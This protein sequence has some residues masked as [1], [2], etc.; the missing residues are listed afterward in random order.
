MVIGCDRLAKQSPFGVDFKKN[1]LHITEHG[2]TPMIFPTLS[3]QQ[4]VKE[5][6]SEEMAKLLTKSASG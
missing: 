1:E 3:S 5:I 4:V 2:I 6:Q